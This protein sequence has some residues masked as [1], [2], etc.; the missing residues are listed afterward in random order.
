MSDEQITGGS[1]IGWGIAI[2]AACGA[3]WFFMRPAPIVVPVVPQNTFQGSAPGVRLATEV[4]VS[5][6]DPEIFSDLRVRMGTIS[7]PR[8]NDAPGALK[9]EVFGVGP[10]V[11]GECHA[12]KLKGAQG[13]SHFHTSERVGEGRLAELFGDEAT[14]MTTRQPGLS[15]RMFRE[16]DRYYQAVLWKGKEV[17]RAAIDLVFGSGKLGFTYGYWQGEELFELPVSFLTMNDSWVNSPGYADGTA[18]YSRP[19]ISDCL[20]CHTTYASSYTADPGNFRFQNR[21]LGLGV[22]CERCHGDGRRH[23]SYHREN[24]QATGSKFITDPRKLDQVQLNK[25]CLECHGGL[26]AVTDAK[27]GVHS[28]NQSQRL[29]MSACFKESGGMRCT[30]CHNPHQFER[31]NQELFAQRCQK[32]HEVEDCG[33]FEEKRRL[34]FATNCA[35]CHMERKPLM[36]IAIQTK[37][38][39]V[40]PELVDHFIRVVK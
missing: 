20:T 34:H 21:D 12:E 4:S 37:D 28:N 27:P 6:D 26:D 10:K 22:T 36:D 5:I 13:T 11:C 19:I 3:L 31:D 2:L 39:I 38:E 29:A 32:C 8:T 33:G 7:V 23:V 30:D 40:Y 14:E 1:G 24:P 9:S 25:L 15:F 18:L 35:K 17:H 16:E